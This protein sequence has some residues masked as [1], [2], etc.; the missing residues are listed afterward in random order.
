VARVQMLPVIEPKDFDNR[1]E[2]LREVRGR[3]AEALPE[4]MQPLEG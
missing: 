4:E 1:E 2:L 3:I